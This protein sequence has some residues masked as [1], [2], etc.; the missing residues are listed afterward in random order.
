MTDRMRAYTFGFQRR[1]LYRRGFRMTRYERVDS[2]PCYG[3]AISIDEQGIGGIPSSD[4]RQEFRH[5]LFPEW[6]EPH[7]PAFPMDFR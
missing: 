6:A 3:I 7:F 5:C 1:D 4:E 2:K